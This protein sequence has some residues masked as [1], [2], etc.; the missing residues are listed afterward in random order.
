MQQEEKHRAGWW[1][2]LQTVLLTAIKAVRTSR[3]KLQTE[4]LGREGKRG[5]RTYFSA[6]LPK[7]RVWPRHK[8]RF[9]SL[10]SEH[11]MFC[12]PQTVQSLSICVCESVKG[13]HEGW[14]QIKPFP[15]AWKCQEINRGIRA[16]QWSSIWGIVT[17]SHDHRLLELAKSL[18][19]SC[20]HLLI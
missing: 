6:L 10:L 17:E 12:L 8:I 16:S 14:S 18:S 11:T 9:F 7:V 4:K 3:E 2:H 20:I 1:L 5:A 15:S 13:K 19:Y